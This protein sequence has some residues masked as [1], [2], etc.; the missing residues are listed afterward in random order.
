MR[1]VILAAGDGGR[2][3]HLTRERPKPLVEVAGRPIIAY[4]LDALAAAGI[5]DVA[6]ILGYRAAQLG[7]ALAA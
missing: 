4:T 6:V 7:E 2:L 1:A 5:R 3:G